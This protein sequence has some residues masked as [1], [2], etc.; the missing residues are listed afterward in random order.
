MSVLSRQNAC[1][2]E[3]VSSSVSSAPPPPRE[4]EKQQV[5]V[6]LLL[7]LLPCGRACRPCHRTARPRTPAGTAYRAWK[8]ARSP[9]RFPPPCR[10][11]IRRPPR[12]R[13]TPVRRSARE[14]TRRQPHSTS[15]DRP[16]GRPKTTRN[17]AGGRCRSAPFCPP[18][19]EAALRTGCSR[20]AADTAPR[21]PDENAPTLRSAR[22]QAQCS[23]ANARQNRRERS[24]STQRE[25][26]S[27]SISQPIQQFSVQSE[28]M[29]RN[30]L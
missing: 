26:S 28:P 23:R 24:R 9:V 4:G 22:P 18:L 8:T 1:D 15:R 19:S 5:V 17:T 27:T 13:Q 2:H 30:A 25:S 14:S 16:H 29:H 6:L 20:S 3:A 12:S 10:F 11:R 7:R 21:R